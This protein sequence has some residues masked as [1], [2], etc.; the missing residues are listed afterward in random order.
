[1]G[2]I[3]HR[4]MQ[5]EPRR[6][7]REPRAVAGWAEV[8]A[9]EEPPRPLLIGEALVDV[10][11][12][13]SRRLGG[14]PFNVAWHLAGFGLDPVFVTR[15]GD[16]ADGERLLEAMRGWEM[17]TAG[18]QVDAERPTGRVVV[19]LE[20]GQPSYEIVADQ[21]W[22]RIDPGAA[23]KAAAWADGPVCHG[24]LACRSERSRLA[25]EAVRRP[26]SGRVLV[27][28]NLREG[29]WEPE[30]V[31]SMLVGTR[32]IKVNGDE[33][34][35]VAPGEGATADL[36]R[37]LARQ[38]GADAVL[39]TLGEEGAEVVWREG[40]RLAEAPPGRV[41]VVD[42]VGAGDAFTAVIVAG[43]CLG[44]AMGDSL[45]RALELAARVCGVRGAVIEDR[46]V[47]RALAARW[48]GGT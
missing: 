20:G 3:D 33:L 15:V 14:A 35:L 9:E 7:A 24:S 23:V 27:D 13:G 25:V 6:A 29:W 22:D 28:L 36:A 30:A 16:D 8:R 11:P 31:A 38:T 48:L 26:A 40:G 42:T 21:A 10:F 4:A 19:S 44:W 32:W 39:V 41:E 45:A 18:V 17:E 5:V 2:E 37:G 34:R 43:L 47:Y 46:E 1:M 12:D